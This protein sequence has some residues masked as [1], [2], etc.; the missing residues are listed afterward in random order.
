M[1]IHLTSQMLS[2]KAIRLHYLQSRV[3]ETY[4]FGVSLEE[5]FDID[6]VSNVSGVDQY[7]VGWRNL[8]DMKICKLVS[9]HKVWSTKSCKADV[10]LFNG[11]CVKISD[12]I[13]VKINE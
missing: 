10:E 1:A 11:L 5:R 9:I 2:D 3:D 8:M 4:N 6:L 12:Q 7:L 13:A